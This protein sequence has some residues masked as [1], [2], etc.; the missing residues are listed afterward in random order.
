M[1]CSDP[2]AP[3]QLCCEIGSP[4]IW[5]G[6]TAQEG[7][8]ELGSLEAE[9]VSPSPASLVPPPHLLSSARLAARAFVTRHCDLV[10][11]LSPSLE[12]AHRRS[13]PKVSLLPSEGVGLHQVLSECLG[14]E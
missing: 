7:G 14:N 6:P 11:F 12:D 8:R 2:F 1:V 13:I 3:H 4:D 9:P 10:C 5:P